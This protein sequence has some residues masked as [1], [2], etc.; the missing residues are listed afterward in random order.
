MLLISII[1]INQKRVSAHFELLNVNRF[2]NNTRKCIPYLDS[3]RNKTP[4]VLTSPVSL[5]SKGNTISN[6]SLPNDTYRMSQ[7]RQRCMQWVI[8]NIVCFMQQT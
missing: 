1:I 4:S 3:G 7:I 2:N 8:S 6:V 5:N